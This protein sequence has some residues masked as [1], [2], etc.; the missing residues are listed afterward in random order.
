MATAKQKQS[1]K[2]VEPDFMIDQ[3][4]PKRKR[5]VVPFLEDDGS[6]PTIA[7]KFAEEYSTLDW[8]DDDVMNEFW[9]RIALEAVSTAEVPGRYST[10][11]KVYMFADDSWFDPKKNEVGN[12]TWTFVDEDQPDV[13]TE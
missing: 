12:S 6:K 2:K 8:D 4:E 7:D 3:G 5:R 13:R 10:E 11:H 9:T 1:K